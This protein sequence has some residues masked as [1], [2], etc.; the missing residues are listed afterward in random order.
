MKNFKLIATTIV[1]CAFVITSCKKQIVTSNNANLQSESALSK[2]TTLIS[3]DLQLKLNTLRASMPAGYKERVQ[4]NTALLLKV[5]PEYRAMVQR[6]LN[7]TAPNSCNDN[8]PLNQLLANQL[9]DW[10]S[11]IIYFA[12][13]T[14]MLDFP[15][16]DALLFEN[17]PATQYFGVKGEYTQ[18]MAK[19]FKDLKRFWNIQ[20]ANILLAGMHGSMLLNRDKLIRIDMILYGDSQA[21]AAYTADLIITLLKL[22][23]Q[24]MNG[25]HPIFTFNSFAQN[26]FTFPPYGLIPAKIVMG[27]GIMQDFTVTGYGDVAPQAI[28]AH[29][30]GH[31][32][33]FQLGIFGT[34]SSPE[35]TRRTELMADAYSAYYL[36]HSRGA[37][38]QWKRV[39]LFLQVFF[40]IG[41]CQVT[42]NGHHGTPTQR[43]ASAQWAYSVANDA[44]KQGHILTSQEFTALFE[45]QLP[46]LL[47]K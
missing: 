39:Q 19:T 41:D 1:L 7:A 25:D 37:S 15:T 47:L 24:Y 21:T 46:A 33:Q 44:Q 4:K 35:A 14:G 32:V 2:Q 40:N 13:A 23:P 20:S 30:F 27:D 17:N 26:S 6:I 10:N 16:Y 38:M 43:M 8:T 42:N 22:V 5:H 18:I 31:Q 9:A 3:A 45:K 12:L 36:S 34:V 28:L 29:E 11:D